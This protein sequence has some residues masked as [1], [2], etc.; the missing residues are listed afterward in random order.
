[1]EFVYSSFD[2][3]AAY[4]ESI[5]E[6][7]REKG[8]VL[9]GLLLEFTMFYYIWGGLESLIAIIEPQPVKAARGLINAACRFLKINYDADRPLLFYED[10]IIR[11]KDIMTLVPDYSDLCCEFRP[12]EFIG[13]SGIG[14]HVIHKIRNRLF[15]G[16]IS[17]PEP[18]AYTDIKSYDSELIAIS[19]R[20]CLLTIQM[21][22]L[23][24]FN[25]HDEIG[26]CWSIYNE[27]EGKKDDI[28]HSIRTMHLCS[29]YS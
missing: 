4:C 11:M 25:A 27:R 15:H 17:F 21:L 12:N 16:A 6:Y 26:L 23:A 28:M 20:L 7:Y 10:L 14:L 2:E 8:E 22:L 29:K 3:D 5:A 19:S 24:Y 13:M 18:E 9:S 1:M